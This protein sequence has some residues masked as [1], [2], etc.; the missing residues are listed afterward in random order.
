MQKNDE[1]EHEVPLSKQAMEILLLRKQARVSPYIFPSYDAR[2]HL[3]DH[4]MSGLLRR[5][6]I[7]YTVH[8]TTRSCFKRWALERTSFP[9]ELIEMSLAHKV[10]N[11][12]EQAYA[13]DAQAIERRRPLMQEWANFCDNFIG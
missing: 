8:G 2:E 6:G 11:A 1:R 5:K 10:G 13:R 9:R 3:D 12:V 7:R 4:A